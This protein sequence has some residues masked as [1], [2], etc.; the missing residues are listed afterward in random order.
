MSPNQERKDEREKI[1]GDAIGVIDYD[2]T[3]GG[4][5]DDNAPWHWDSTLRT[6]VRWLQQRQQW[7]QCHFALLRK[8]PNTLRNSSPSLWRMQIFHT[9]LTLLEANSEANHVVRFLNTQLCYTLM[10]CSNDNY[11]SARKEI[12]Y[13]LTGGRDIMTSICKSSCSFVF[14]TWNEN[15]YWPRKEK[16]RKENKRN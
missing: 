7:Y 2:A 1:G 6:G 11:G 10:W 8:K 12:T 4:G 14:Q 13:T 16:K 15:N 5:M 9:I 3:S